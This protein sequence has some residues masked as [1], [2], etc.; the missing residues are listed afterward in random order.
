MALIQGLD[1]FSIHTNN[2]G[3]ICG[4]GEDGIFAD[5]KVTEEEDADAEKEAE[6]MRR[7]FHSLSEGPCDCHRYV[8]CDFKCFRRD[9][10]E[11]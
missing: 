9:F 3:E 10:I 6:I 8:E 2:Y 7:M 4:F 5:D 1:Y 11:G